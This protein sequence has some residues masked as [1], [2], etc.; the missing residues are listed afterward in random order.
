MSAPRSENPGYV[1]GQE[2]AGLSADVRCADM[3]SEYSLTFRAQQ[4]GVACMLLR[5]QLLTSVLQCFE[6]MIEAIC[7]ARIIITHWARK[8]V[9]SGRTAGGGCQCWLASGGLVHGRT[10]LVRECV[11]A[12]LLCG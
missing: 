4:L 7:S 11:T 12:R 2:A 10:W 8:T 9:L 3:L 6:F 5:L 1:Y